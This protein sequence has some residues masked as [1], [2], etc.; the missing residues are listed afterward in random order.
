MPLSFC[1]QKMQV[2]TKILMKSSEVAGFLIGQRSL[3]L[4]LF[5]PNNQG[6][7]REEIA[8]SKAEA[9]V[10]GTCGPMSETALFLQLGL[11]SII[12]PTKV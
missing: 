2:K 4:R 9:E 11:F 6:Q 8:L 7:Y 5:F 1:F 12:Q 10:N 3:K